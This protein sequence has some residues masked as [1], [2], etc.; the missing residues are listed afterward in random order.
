MCS[1]FCLH[2]RLVGI[3]DL[4]VLTLFATTH[5][6]WMQLLVQPQLTRPLTINLSKAS[7]VWRMAVTSSCMSLLLLIN[8]LGLCNDF[9]AESVFLWFNCLV[10]FIISI[11][12]SPWHFS[13]IQIL[14][15]I[16]AFSVWSSLVHKIIQGTVNSVSLVFTVSGSCS[17]SEMS[18]IL[19]VSCTRLDRML[20]IVLQII[21]KPTG[22]PVSAAEDSQS[23]ESLCVTS[24]CT[25]A[26][27]V[28]YWLFWCTWIALFLWLAF[29]A[30]LQH[31]RVSW[32]FSS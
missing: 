2:Y 6:E 4:S 27:W 19:H 30:C 1:V 22:R 17:F 23:P 15:C 3:V 13:G 11:S 28:C 20:V 18:R 7:T 29:I 25:S 32:A 16:K 5:F 10:L 24:V 12:T 9:R 8:I 14:N 31:Y 26:L 21:P